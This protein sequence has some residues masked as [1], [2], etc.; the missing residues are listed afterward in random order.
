M[1][2]YPTS[3][4]STIDVE[5]RAMVGCVPDAQSGILL[6]IMLFRT[7]HWAV[8]GATAS[9]NAEACIEQRMSIQ[10]LIYPV[11]HGSGAYNLENTMPHATAVV[12]PLK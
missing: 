7:S 11:R 4:L 6:P 2:L 1:I 8:K 3:Y 10:E 9:T 5:A 12:M